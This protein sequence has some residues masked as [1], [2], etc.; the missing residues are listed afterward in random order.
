M[1]LITQTPK[2]SLNKAFLKQPVNRDEI[3][4]FKNNLQTLLGKINESESEEHHKY[5]VRDFLK[6][7]FYKTDYEMNT[8]GRQDLVIHT[9]KLTSDP[10][11]VILEAKK[12]NKPAE[13]ITAD[14]P[15][16]K[17]LQELVLYFLR[18][19]IDEKNNDVKYLIVTNINEWFVFE[20]S[21]FNRLFFENKAFVKEYKDWRDKLKITS[22]TPLF[23]NEIV[24]PYIESIDEI[25]PCTYF[26]IRDYET[27]L[28]NDDDKND[29]S[30]IG[31]FQD[32]FADAS[33]ETS[34][35]R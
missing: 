10:V 16:K 8:K 14:N 22:N 29:E 20:A 7:T 27:A 21:I 31:T 18:E 12:P 4:T 33:F 30:L 6:D 2:Q 9:G 25:I 5:P 34:V 13:M 35:C 11:G 19:R 23:Y 26:D 24:K 28:K 32:S 17:A 1:K 3:D 15:N